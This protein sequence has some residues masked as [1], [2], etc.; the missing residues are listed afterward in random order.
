MTNDANR[1][2]NINAEALR[3]LQ[4]EVRIQASLAQPSWTAVHSHYYFDP[5]KRVWRELDA[6]AIRWWQGLL[7]RHKVLIKLAIL[8]ES[9][10]LRQK[11]VLLPAFKPLRQAII[12]DWIGGMAHAEERRKILLDV[13]VDPRI[14]Y[15]LDREISAGAYDAMP[16]APN[17]L[18]PPKGEEWDAAAFVEALNSGKT[19]ENLEDSAIWKARLG[20]QSAARAMADQQIEED[21]R[22]IA[23]AIR[24]ALVGQL[25]AA[26]K[27]FDLKKAFIDNVTKP[28]TVTVFHPIIVIDA[29]LWGVSDKDTVPVRHARIHLTNLSGFPYFWF[30]LVHRDA[31]QEVIACAQ[32][33]YDL[34]TQEKGLVP[35]SP[36]M[37]LADYEIA[38]P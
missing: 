9:K 34:Q 31:A 8:V 5:V 26:G 11:H 12:F 28:F 38:R 30:D 1:P 16:N 35:F 7:D 22:E 37:G 36:G 32:E 6:A 23:M 24:R 20:L 33:N 27:P 13:G 14:S 29:N 10:H 18:Y 19:S 4:N 2:P 21:A 17:I 25:G 15:Q 3:S